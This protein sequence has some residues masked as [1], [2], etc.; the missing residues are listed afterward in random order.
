MTASNHEAN[1]ML[2]MKIEVTDSYKSMAVIFQY[3]WGGGEGEG[4]CGWEC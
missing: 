2:F 1:K 3:L 4:R